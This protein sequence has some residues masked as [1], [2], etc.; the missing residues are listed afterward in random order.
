MTTRLNSDY[1][2][3]K[4]EPTTTTC[5]IITTIKVNSVYN[6]FE[7]I[8]TTCDNKIAITRTECATHQQTTSQLLTKTLKEQQQ[9]LYTPKN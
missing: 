3:F 6:R 9:I 1:I 2:R 7:T 4:I 5:I 8:T